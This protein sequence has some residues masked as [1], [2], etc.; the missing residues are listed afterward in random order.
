MLG[1]EIQHSDK[2]LVVSLCK[3]LLQRGLI[4][5]PCGLESTVLSLTPPFT[6]QKEHID[7]LISELDTLLPAG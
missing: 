5:L 7:F 2:Y 1:L 3:S 4:A 6:I